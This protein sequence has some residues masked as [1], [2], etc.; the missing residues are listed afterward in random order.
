MWETGVKSQRGW[1]SDAGVCVCVGVCRYVCAFGKWSRNRCDASDSRMLSPIT[2]TPC[3]S[4]QTTFFHFAFLPFFHSVFYSRYKYQY[5][6]NIVLLKAS[7]HSQ[8]TAHVSVRFSCRKIM[9]FF[10]FYTFIMNRS[11]RNCTSFA[12]KA[13]SPKIGLHEFEYVWRKRVI[14][15]FR[16]SISTAVFS[17]KNVHVVVLGYKWDPE[18]A[19]FFSLWFR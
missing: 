7:W 1:D 18:A 19:I 14:Q 8:K 12:L 2:D 15:S 4:L 9:I 10:F 6:S 3:Q 11:N 16:F 13:C 5:V 17:F